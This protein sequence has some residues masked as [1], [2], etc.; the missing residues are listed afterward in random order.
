MPSTVFWLGLTLMLVGMAIATSAIRTVMTTTIEKV[1]A[2]G[3][4]DELPTEVLQTR[5]ARELLVSSNIRPFLIIFLG[6]SIGAYGLL[7]MDTGVI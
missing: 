7:I 5:I 6:A 3:E 1:R 4:V 2:Q